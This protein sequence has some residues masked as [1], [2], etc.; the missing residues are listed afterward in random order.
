MQIDW[1]TVAAQ[2]LNF[3][4]LLWILRGLVYRPLSRAM[5]DREA[6]LRDSFARAEAE[7]EAAREKAAA[8]EDERAALETRRAELVAAAEADA[9]TLVD[10]LLDE[11]RAEA[12]AQ[13]A[14]WAAQ[15][16]REGETLVAEMR[17]RAAHSLVVLARRTLADLASVPLEQAIATA[18]AARL[19]ALPDETAAALR[20]AAARED[21]A[22]IETAFAVGDARDALTDAATAL[23]GERVSLHF[24][25]NADLVCG[26]RLRAGGQTVQWSLD[27]WVDRFAEEL[28]AAL[29]ALAPAPAAGEGAR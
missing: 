28:E 2:I 29:D 15:I 19:A 22:T 3:L 13:R 23:L 8:L 18:F 21:A 1:I 17:R 10:Q 4:V 16:A 9:R 7:T 27:A 6:R 20:K 26:V 14:A 5:A 12:E 11:A 24:A 25:Q